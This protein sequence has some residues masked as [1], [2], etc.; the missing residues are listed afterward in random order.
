MRYGREFCLALLFHFQFCLFNY[1]NTSDD[2][3]ITNERV[4]ITQSCTLHNW[5]NFAAD[6]FSPVSLKKY[7][8]GGGASIKDVRKPGGGCL[9]K[10][11]VCG[12]RWRG[13]E[14][15]ADVQGPGEGS[16]NSDTCG[17]GGGGLKKA[18][19]ADIL[20]HYGCP[21]TNSSRRSPRRKSHE[22]LAYIF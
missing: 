2:D 1:Y 21:L 5:A 11:D 20:Y 16:R 14:E 19:I 4:V 10:A 8:L 3:V 6:I 13:S 22:M 12:C 18:K 15:N 17:Q 7:L 9:V